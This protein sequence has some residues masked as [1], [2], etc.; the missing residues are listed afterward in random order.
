MLQSWHSTVLH[1]NLSLKTQKQYPH[2]QSCKGKQ[3]VNSRVDQAHA[4]VLFRLNLSN[5]FVQGTSMD[6]H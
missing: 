5:F 3:Y 2:A 4:K 1:I 6:I